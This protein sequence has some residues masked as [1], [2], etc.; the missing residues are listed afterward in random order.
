VNSV[1]KNNPFFF[2]VAIKR[3]SCTYFW[4]NQCPH[5]FIQSN[6]V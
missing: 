5:S 1:K 4:S 6:T 3:K 2:T